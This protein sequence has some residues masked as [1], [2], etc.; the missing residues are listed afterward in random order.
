MEFRHMRLKKQQ[1]SESEVVKILET[2]KQG[3]LSMYGENGYPY[4][5]PINYVYHNGDIYFHG[6]VVGKKL[7]CILANPKVCF[8]VIDKDDV[9][10]NEYTT[11][12]TSAICY[13]TA[14]KLSSELDKSE[15][16]LA[17]CNKY[18]PALVEESKERIKKQIKT[19][20]VVKIKI[21]YMTGK[22]ASELL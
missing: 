11:Y 4:S 6:A 7:D 2:A 10:K 19:V 17:I 22:I 3:V 5:T 20:S 15:G 8:T 18:M 14:Y 16:L 1:L 9:I 12:F 13:G 21:D